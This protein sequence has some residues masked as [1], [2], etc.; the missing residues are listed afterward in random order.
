MQGKVQGRRVWYPLPDGY[1]TSSD[2]RVGQDLS[3]D[4]EI[5]LEEIIRLIGRDKAKRKGKGLLPL[6]Y[7]SAV[8]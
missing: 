5:K 6:H 7:I 1:T 8:K 3:D 4:D 2:A